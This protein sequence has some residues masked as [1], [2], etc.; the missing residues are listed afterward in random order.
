MIV[1]LKIKSFRKIFLKGFF[2]GVLVFN[3]AIPTRFVHA[4]L[5]GAAV[6]ATLL[7]QTLLTI[8][9]QIM[10]AIL[11]TL[12]VALIEILNSKVGQMIGGSSVGNSLIIT[13]W[14]EY[15]YTQPAEQVTLYMNDWFSA[16][17]RGKYSSSNY[18]GVGDVASNVE[19]NYAAYLVRV[20]DDAIIAK[21]SAASDDGI[22]LGPAYDLD[23]YT[24]S[25]GE[26]FKQ[27]NWR[28][29]NAFFSNPMNNPFGYTLSA[30]AAAQKKMAQIQRTLE[31]K[32]QSSGFKAPEKDGQVIAPVAT[33][34][35]MAADVQNIGNNMIAAAT[36]PGEFLAGVVGALVNKTVTNLVQR[37][38]GKVQANIKREIRNYDKKVTEEVNRL[39]KQLGPAARY[40]D[41]VSQRTDTKIKPYTTPPPRARDTGTYCGGGC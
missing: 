40:L 8:R 35:A 21:E 39:D 13:N 7:N 20:A 15:L 32:S 6:G 10:S 30:E 27:G 38:V 25:P 2:I 9:E 22:R 18:V 11:G 26:M 24:A 33:L 3:V 12:K 17:T 23:E 29:F 16:T 36:N 5:W 4:E 34:E 41:N 28:A 31:I 1:T 14:E 37:G 19:G